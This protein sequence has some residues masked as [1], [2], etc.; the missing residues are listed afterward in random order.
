MRRPMI[1]YLKLE[2]F[3]NFQEATL[4]MGPF[5]VLVGTNA[6]GK[7]NLR[8]AFRVVHGLSRGYTLA[9]T[10]GE[11]WI[12][13]GV[14]QWRGIRGGAREAAFHGSQGFA[15]EVGFTLQVEEVLQEAVYRIEINVGSALAPP[16]VLAEQLSVSGQEHPIYTARR[17]KSLAEPGSFELVLQYGGLSLKERDDGPMVPYPD[18]RPALLQ[19]SIFDP[20]DYR[21]EVMQYAHATVQAL[22]SMRFLDL[23]PEAI[24][25][26][27]LPGQT[28]LGDRG[29]N[30]SSVLQAICRNESTRNGL[31]EWVRALT[32]LDV[33]DFEFVPDWVFHPRRWR[34]AESRGERRHPALHRVQQCAAVL[35]LQGQQ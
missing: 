7:S 33:V 16:H 2:R 12:D 32:P 5:T 4:P 9:E 35:S 29:E 17:E 24:R 30:L 19:Q 26:P 6:S 15:L 1:R 14:L 23:S 28:I 3:K 18:D 11:K 25:I 20:S 31:V 34:S 27:S 22:E 21:P 8:D 13:G 10:L